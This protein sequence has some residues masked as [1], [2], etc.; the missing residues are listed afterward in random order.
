MIF[1]TS[2][3]VLMSVGIICSAG[4]PQQLNHTWVQFQ[5]AVKKADVEAV[6]TM[7]H[8]PLRSNDFGG[9]IKSTSVFKSKYKE[10][11]SSF[12]VGKI[13][14]VS[15]KKINGYKGFVADCSDPDGLA[16]VFGFEK[17]GDKYLLS[18]IDNANE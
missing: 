12:V 3:P 4:T 7:V 13:T 8:F 16:L 18:Y 6:A 1:Q 9:T 14:T 2:V 11:F 10:I 17:Y 15:L 5:E